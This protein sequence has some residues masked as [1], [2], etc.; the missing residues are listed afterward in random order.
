MVYIHNSEIHSTFIS[1]HGSIAVNMN[2]EVMT[3][4]YITEMEL[5]ETGSHPL[6][7]KT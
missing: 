4:M 5:E 1:I 2:E 7:K 6:Q 3:R